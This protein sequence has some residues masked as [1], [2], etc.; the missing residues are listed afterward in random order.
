[1]EQTELN[2]TI[3]FD[4]VKVLHLIP[5]GEPGLLVMARLDDKHF[6][7]GKHLSES[8]GEDFTHVDVDLMHLELLLVTL[9]PPVSTATGIIS[10]LQLMHANTRKQENKTKRKQMLKSKSFDCP[11]VLFLFTLYCFVVSASFILS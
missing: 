7:V 8:V 4:L 3:E 5:V 6:V 1:M 2:Q 9:G 10:H 11:H